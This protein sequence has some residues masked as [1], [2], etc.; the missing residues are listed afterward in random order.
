MGIYAYIYIF[1]YIHIYIFHPYLFI[2]TSKQWCLASKKETISDLLLYC[3][4]SLKKL[5]LWTK[6]ADFKA[7]LR[8]IQDKLETSFMR[9]IKCQRMM[10]SCQK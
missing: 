7:E 10:E 9:F 1:I 4:F 3:S 8:K 5:Q 2:E 6:M